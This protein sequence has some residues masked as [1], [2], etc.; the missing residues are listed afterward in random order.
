MVSS[1][2]IG[3]KWQPRKGLS[4]IFTALVMVTITINSP[5]QSSPELLGEHRPVTCYYFVISL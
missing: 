4:R 3:R 1:F 2:G 5:H